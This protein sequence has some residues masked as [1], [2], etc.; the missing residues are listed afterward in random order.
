MLEE[1]YN[2]LKAV[3]TGRK[4]A[5]TGTAP[6]A[7]YS[8]PDE[9]QEENL[10]DLLDFTNNLVADAAEN[11]NPPEMIA[12]SRKANL[13]F[14][15]ARDNQSAG[16]SRLDQAKHYLSYLDK[17]LYESDPEDPKDSDGLLLAGIK[18]VDL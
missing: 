2:T 6:M 11:D 5:F 8:P 17:A 1:V 14:S 15:M 3:F 4:T 13:L 7:R 18:R 12:A 16:R 9:L 10:Q